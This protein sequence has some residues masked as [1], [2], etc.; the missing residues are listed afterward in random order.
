VTYRRSRGSEEDQT[1]QVRS[2]LVAES[3]SSVDESTDT[4]RLQR[5]SNQ[6]RTPRHGRRRSLPRSDELLL[7]VGHLSTLV[8]LP[9]QRRQDCNQRSVP[10][11]RVAGEQNRKGGVEAHQQAQ[12]HG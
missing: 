4:V 5:R 6:R 7:G 8:G 9:E 12:C 1:A 3:S 10:C 2:A 11:P